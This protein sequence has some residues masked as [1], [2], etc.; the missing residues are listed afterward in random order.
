MVAKCASRLPAL[1]KIVLLEQADLRMATADH[2]EVAD[3]E[4]EIAVHLH[5]VQ[6]EMEETASMVHVRHTS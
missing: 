1:W 5:T 4:E 6:T 2:H 3:T